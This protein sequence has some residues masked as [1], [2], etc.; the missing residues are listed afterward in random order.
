[1]VFI[2]GLGQGLS[3]YLAFLA[4]LT[5]GDRKAHD[6]PDPDPAPA[7][8]AADSPAAIAAALQ[9]LAAAA[10][11][12]VFLVEMSY[13]AGRV[14]EQVP[15]SLQV[16]D[17]I[18]SMLAAHGYAQA[19]F[20]GHSFGS[21]SAAW[22]IRYRPQMVA[23]CMLIDP[24][25]LCL[26]WPTT[27]YQFVYDEPRSLAQ[28]LRCLAVSKELGIDRVMKRSF[29]WLENCMFL[30]NLPSRPVG[31]HK[32][33]QL[34]EYSKSGNLF[35]GSHELFPVAGHPYHA[36]APATIGTAAAASLYNTAS[37]RPS[38]A[39]A[40][41]LAP[42][43]ETEQAPDA[44]TAP[45]SGSGSGS[46]SSLGFVPL[47]WEVDVYGVFAGLGYPPNSSQAAAVEEDLAI[48]GAERPAPAP[49]AERGEVFLAHSA[50]APEAAVPEAYG[51]RNRLA[52]EAKAPDLTASAS[53]PFPSPLPPAPDADADAPAAPAAPAAAAAAAPERQIKLAV[54]LAGCDDLLPAP[55]I[56]NHMR[57]F[58]Q[59]ARH[60][61]AAATDAATA[62]AAADPLSLLSPVSAADEPPAHEPPAHA[63][64]PPPAARAAFRPSA[65]HV[66]AGGSRPEEAWGGSLSQCALGRQL[67]WATRRG[68]RIADS[69]PR[70]TVDPRNYTHVGGS[71]AVPM[72]GPRAAAAAVD[73]DVRTRV[74][75]APG[76]GHGHVLVSPAAAAQLRTLL[77]WLTEED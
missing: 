30:Q 77:K 50:P 59:Q 48:G 10:G 64:A 25:A 70:V 53:F 35:S 15:S 28:A 6:A 34:S 51:L 60:A 76:K 12:D 40:P 20:V 29:W 39:A 45:G 22:C 18:A 41:S 44:A 7:D 19:T 23:S 57:L 13:I 8:A 14:W 47:P 26:C 68:L 55:R 73:V 38:L 21:F 52:P 56:L 72:P 71:S 27:C 69:Q 33:N 11:R 1:V 61:T 75:Y 46:G 5:R 3:F 58:Y 36:H 17:F 2:H 24:V 43:P 65:L 9:A 4:N 16:V 67:A 63:H 37:R 74:L 42:T 54:Y 62:A 32:R 66:G 31:D 49:P